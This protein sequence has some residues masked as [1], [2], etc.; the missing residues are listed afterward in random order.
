MR[1]GTMPSTLTSSAFRVISWISFSVIILITSPLFLP[2]T[3]V[4][5]GLM[6]RLDDLVRIHKNFPCARCFFVSLR[7]WFRFNRLRESGNLW[8]RVENWPPFN[9]TFLLSPTMRCYD[10]HCYRQEMISIL[11]M[12][13]F[14]WKSLKEICLIHFSSDLKFMTFRDGSFFFARIF[15]ISVIRQT[16]FLNYNFRKC[17]FLHL[18]FSFFDCQGTSQIT[19]IEHDAK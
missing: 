1:R 8:F 9:C 15:H 5:L 13:F 10:C 18:L 14:R 17:P 7:N 19:N 11:F 4:H 2:G 3:D 12:P 16:E 6:S